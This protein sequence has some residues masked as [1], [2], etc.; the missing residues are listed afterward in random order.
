M[1]NKKVLIS[2]GAV[3][4]VAA[5]VFGVAAMNKKAPTPTTMDSNT[6]G[7]ADTN[8]ATTATTPIADK[9]K[10]G[11]TTNGSSYKD[12]TYTA[13]GSYNSPGGKDQISVTVQL[14]NDIV[15]SASITPMPGDPTSAKYQNMFA[16]GY[17]AYVIGKNIDAV[18][19]NAV[20]GSSL[21]GIGFNDAI[22]KIK[23]QAKA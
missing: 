17:Q 11:T 23:A 21:T 18:H 4:V 16:S 14:R 7:Q 20:S 2:A 6:S 9:P 19:L 22:T 8:T 12:G 15:T 5:G 13:V 10:T 3:V 1:N